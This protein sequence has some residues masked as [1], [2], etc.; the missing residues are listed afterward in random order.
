MEDRK[1]EKTKREE[2]R[3]DEKFGSRAGSRYFADYD[4]KKEYN[5]RRGRMETKRVYVGEYYIQDITMRQKILIRVLYLALFI[6]SVALFV[7]CACQ[8]TGS[9]FA[10]YVTLPQVVCVPAMMW[11]VGGFMMYLP[12]IGKIQKWDYKHGAVTLRRTS[13]VSAVCL[14]VMA[15][16][17]LAFYVFHREESDSQTLLN[18]LLFGLAA[19][20]M[21]A[22]FITEKKIPYRIL[23]N[24]EK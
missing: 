9:N 24:G 1:T 11:M 15:L 12:G 23:E 6:A 5:P 13:L 18:V 22:V 20:M 16:G 14:G 2:R 19:C 7:H 3:A 10:W 21:A 4:V 8:S 17:T